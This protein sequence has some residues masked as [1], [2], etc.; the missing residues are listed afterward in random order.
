MWRMS[1]GY[2]R[3]HTRVCTGDISCDLYTGVINKI[4]G[5]VCDYVYRKMRESGKFV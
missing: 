3:R 1:R 2:V 5:G 4:F